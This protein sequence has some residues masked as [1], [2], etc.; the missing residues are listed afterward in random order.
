MTWTEIQLP[1]S[2]YGRTRQ[3]ADYREMSLAE[4]FRMALTLRHWGVDEFYT[5][6]AKDFQDIDFAQLINPFYL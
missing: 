3:Y 2:L 6:N 1:D 4:V 5:R